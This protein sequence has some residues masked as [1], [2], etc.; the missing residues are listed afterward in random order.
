MKMT[1]ECDTGFQEQNVEID[2]ILVDILDTFLPDYIRYYTTEVLKLRKRS[3]TKKICNNS[4][5][6]IECELM[7][8]IL[9]EVDDLCNILC[10]YETPEGFIVKLPYKQLF[11]VLMDHINQRTEELHSERINKAV[12]IIQNRFRKIKMQ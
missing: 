4:F 5:F 8:F 1:E 7:D 12:V 3:F 10:P 9:D 2:T 6:F 11:K